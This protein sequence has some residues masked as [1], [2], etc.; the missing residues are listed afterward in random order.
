MYRHFSD[1]TVNVT[2]GGGG[3]E[4]AAAILKALGGKA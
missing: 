1:L 4:V 3:A 2:E